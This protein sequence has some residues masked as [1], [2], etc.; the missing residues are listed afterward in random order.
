MLRVHT[1]SAAVACVVAQVM[2]DVPE[3]MFSYFT[4]AH[5]R[6]SPCGAL[7]QPLASSALRLCAESLVVLHPL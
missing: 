6:D 2:M 4:Y 5:H 3:C 1:V 7:L